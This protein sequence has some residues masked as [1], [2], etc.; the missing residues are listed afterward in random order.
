MTFPD[1]SYFT[2]AIAD[3]RFVLALLIAAL[4][5]LVRGFSGFGSA[6]IHIPLMAA[7]YSPRIAAVTIV[8]IDFVGAAPL[9]VREF[10]KCNWRDVLP[11]TLAT[12]IAIPLGATALLLIDPVMLR[13]FIAFLILV[14]L[15]PLAVGWRYHGEPKLPL[16]LG[17]GLF[18]GFGAGSV[19]IAAPAVVLYW[20]GATRHIA[21]VRANF[22]VFLLMT[23]VLG[24]LIYGWK[25][26][27]TPDG[28]A[29]AILLAPAFFVAMA[30]G[31]YFFHGASDTLYRRIAYAIIG[32]A[33]VFSLPLFDG[34]LR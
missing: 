7:L 24:I 6:L 28:I 25:G 11:M 9:S 10:P 4:A 8:L 18:A 19:Q 32:F 20:L 14:L 12:A 16:T 1:F 30:C 13:W 15:V 29:L 23:D 17:V 21:T 27:L 22:M 33:A 3:R 2:D 31:S 5:G 26:L 34:I